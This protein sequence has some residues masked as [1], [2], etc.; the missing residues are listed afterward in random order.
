MKLNERSRH[1]WQQTLCVHVRVSH[2]VLNTSN[3]QH[4][5]VPPQTIT[6]AIWW[7]QSLPNV[8]DNPPSLHCCYRGHLVNCFHK[9]SRGMSCVSDFLACPTVLGDL[10]LRCS[11]GWRE[12]AWALLRI[13]FFCGNRLNAHSS[14]GSEKRSCVGRGAPWLQCLDAL[15]NLCEWVMF[16][17]QRFTGCNDSDVDLLPFCIFPEL[18]V[19]Q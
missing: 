3:K 8:C 6:S 2:S 15:I 19:N 13:H 18:N 16:K 1:Q 14:R 7:S 17:T 5:P 9:G 11:L 10:L 12:G 4:L